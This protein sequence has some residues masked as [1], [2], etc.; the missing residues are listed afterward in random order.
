[1]SVKKTVAKK[2]PAIKVKAKAKAKKAVLVPVVH[3]KS[4]KKKK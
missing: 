3:K 2:K 1:M 4:A